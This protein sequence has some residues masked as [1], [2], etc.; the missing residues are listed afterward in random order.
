VR[1]KETID[2]DWGGIVVKC[3]DQLFRWLAPTEICC[4]YCGD[5]MPIKKTEWELPFWFSPILQQVL[6]HACIKSIPWILHIQCTY[7]GRAIP[8]SDCVDK[9]TEQNII[10]KCNRSAVTLNT[11]MKAWLSEYKYKGND[12]YGSLLSAMLLPAFYAV[13]LQNLH[14]NNEVEQW[15]QSGKKLEVLIKQGLIW[16]VVTSV[17]I[18]KQRAYERG[19]NQ[20]E[21]L[22]IHLC[23]RYHL[24]YASLIQRV[25][26]SGHMSHKNKQE[27]GFFV[28]QLYQ[29]LLYSNY[30]Q[31]LQYSS[32]NKKILRV[33]L[34]D[35]VYTT[36]NTIRACAAVIN[37]ALRYNVQV[38]SLTWARA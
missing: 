19:F 29:P 10:V 3:I 13:C 24:Q 9:G 18:S 25:E 6:C 21:Q 28:D 32:K 1:S 23:K 38:Y 27:R 15:Q 34:V 31:L 12:R 36:G 14:H 26:Q 16:D 5:R 2:L 17:P 35:D 37:Q 30:E 7:C 33:L 20:A 22:A 4:I 11:T 8:C